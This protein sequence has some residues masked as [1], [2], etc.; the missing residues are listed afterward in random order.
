MSHYR[1][2]RSLRLTHAKR[3]AAENAKWLIE[4]VQKIQTKKPNKKLGATR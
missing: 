4:K 1:G 2:V 3:Q